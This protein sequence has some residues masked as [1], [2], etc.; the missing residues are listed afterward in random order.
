[1]LDPRILE[2]AARLCEIDCRRWSD[3]Y[4]ESKANYVLI[5]EQLLAADAVDPL[6]RSGPVG[7]N[8]P[9]ERLD[10][11][12]RVLAYLT[13]YGNAEVWDYVL[14]R[15]QKLSASPM[16][17]SD[18]PGRLRQQIIAIRDLCWSTRIDVPCP[19]DHE[20]DDRFAAVRCVDILGI[21][22]NEQRAPAAEPL[23]CKHGC[24]GPHKHRPGADV[25]APW[26]ECPGPVGVQPT[27]TDRDCERCF[28]PL[29]TDDP[30]VWRHD[31]C[32]V[33]PTSAPPTE[34]QP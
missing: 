31:V 6:R 3:L 13:D 2:V 18:A 4:D 34:P 8:P 15:Q 29:I 17:V 10:E 5:A 20:C 9:A 28:G 16:A 11:I 32:P 23:R 25:D 33:A 1:M 24:A 22:N 30:S 26:Q 12:S 14:R 21:I 7:V 27:T 19:D